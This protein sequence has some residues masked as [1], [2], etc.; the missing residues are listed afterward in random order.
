MSMDADM[1]Q[2]YLN[3]EFLPLSQARIPV[4]DRGFLFGDSVYEV[5]PAYRGQ[6][7][8]LSQHL[9]RL[10]DSLHAIHLPNPLQ[11]AQWKHLLTILVEQRTGMDQSV[12][13]QVTRGAAANR[14]HAIPQGLTP[15][16]FAMAT[17][18]PALDP[19]IAEHGIAAITLED[20]RWRQCN[21][22]AT[23]LLANV[24]LRQEAKEHDAMEAILI[25]DGQATEG[26]A[27]NLFIVVDGQLITPPK[28]EYLLPGIT[29]DLVL[30][31]AAEER[32]P[33]CEAPIHHETLESADEIWLTSSTREVIPVTRLNDRTLG[34]GRPGPL[35]QRMRK[36]FQDYKQSL[37]PQD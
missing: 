25:R 5:I 21:I 7:F 13:L 19:A 10:D 22:K 34:H 31:L 28:S 12:Y 6:L 8:R 35:W 24:L 2:V 32:I 15:T 14:D 17:P 29:R 37:P 36:L 1:N 27:S 26:A 11:P 3:G 16:V 23:T 33:Y 9:H 4:M 30:E 18:M 20:I